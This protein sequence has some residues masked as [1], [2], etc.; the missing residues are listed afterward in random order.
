MPSIM[1]QPAQPCCRNAVRLRSSVAVCTPAGLPGKVQGGAAAALGLLAH[2]GLRPR[3]DAWSATL[4]A[5]WSY[6]ALH[7]MLLLAMLAFVIARAASG[8]LR[9]E[10]RSSLDVTALMAHGTAAQA[11]VTL[12]TALWMVRA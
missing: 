4:A 12:V 1:W 10:T 9:A 2:E 11:V 5:L 7:A 8:L 3:A 6:Q